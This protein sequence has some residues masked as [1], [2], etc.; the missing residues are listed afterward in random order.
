MNRI[1]SPLRVAVADDEKDMLEFLQEALQRLG[2]EV[3]AAAQTGTDLV[4]RCRAAQPDLIITDILMPD[5]DGIQ[6][7]EQIERDRPVPVILV[8]AHHDAELIV[9]AGT[10]H[11]MAYMLK[12]IREPDLATAIYLAVLRFEHFQKLTKEAASLR[13]AM[14]DRKLIERAKGIL[15]KRARIDEPEAFRRLQKLASDKNRKLVEIA[16]TLLLAEE[17]FQPPHS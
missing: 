12:P 15:M 3:V 8:S 13:Q 16:Q 6:A 10:D 2:H 1:M 11:I 9:R 5:L 14:E 4:E 17:A 7:V